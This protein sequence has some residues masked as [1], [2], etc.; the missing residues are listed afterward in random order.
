MILVAT[1]PPAIH[2]ETEQMTPFM[3]SRLSLPTGVELEV[4]QSGDPAG[5]PLLLLHGVSDSAP[6]MRPLME[7]L[8]RG[9]R[10]IAV[11]QRGHGDSAKPEGPYTT[12][13][14]AADAAAVLDQLG[15]R[16]AVIFGHSMGSVVAQ[17][18]AARHPERTAGLILEGAF[19]GLKGNT[20]VDAFYSQH[21]AGMQGAM[22]PA[23]AREFQESTLGRPVPPAFLDL[24]VRE[25]QKLPA[26]A[27]RAIFQDMMAL[28]TRPELGAIRAPTLI[29][30]GDKDLFASKA[31]QIDLEARIPGAVLEIFPGTGH[32]PHWEEPVRAAALV[33]RFVQGHLAPAEAAAR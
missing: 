32:D 13:A 8:P 2:Q 14:M 4:I 21:I 25:T 7:R 27:W 10:A 5:A 23:L 22:E 30:W 3:H 28:D 6:S 26:H 9:I 20:A 29:L 24:V 11:T 1:Q 18:F 19:P 31:E 16:R 33:G 17:R 12:D 15:V